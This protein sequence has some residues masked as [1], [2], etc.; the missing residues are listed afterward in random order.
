MRFGS[1]TCACLM[2]GLVFANVASA[3]RLTVTTSRAE[4]LNAQ[5]GDPDCSALSK[6]ADTELPLHIVRLRAVP[7]VGVTGLI[8]Y[9]WSLPTP[10]VGVLVADEDIPS[11]EQAPVIH[12]LCA[13]IGN[14]CILTEEQLKVYS[15]PTILW[16]APKCS[17]ALPAD[18]TKPYR[19]G[20]V[21]VGVRATSGKRKV[22]KGVVSVGY[23]RTASVK[24][25][26]NGNPGQG[27]AV[28]VG[29]E[30]LFSAIIDPSGVQLPLI[31]GFAF[32]NGDGDSGTVGSIGLQAS[33]VLDYS[34]A[35][36]HV[37][38]TTVELHD[39]SALCDN[40]LANVLSSDNRIS[41]S[42]TTNPNPG[43]F[44]PGDPRTGNVDLHVRVKNVSNPAVAR[45]GVLFKGGGV[46]TCETEIRVGSSKLSKTTTIDFQHCS[47]TVDQG[48]DSDADCNKQ[49]CP[50]CE[51]NEVCLAS[52]HCAFSGVEGIRVQ[53]CV[54]D[55]DCGPG[56]QCV[57]VL[58][59]QSLS[60]A[61]G[62][63][64]ELLT[65]RIPI[66][67]TL[68]STAKVKEKWTAHAQNAPDATDSVGYTILSNPSVR[69]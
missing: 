3:R 60:L 36:K 8:R 40:V 61:I 49:A 4:T 1:T 68:P 33:I 43:T 10:A 30:T 11:G 7:P 47:V 16:V 14:E 22:G 52:S 67:N 57:L 66:A 25:A 32:D 63:T 12:A 37:G 31:D 65:A 64:T 39:G 46:L 56:G 5:D 35:G 23:G 2:A 48:C 15:L 21:K 41:L 38:T 6:K 54:R 18:A 24:M 19:G 17:E 9:Q 55:S 29:L 53:P 13:E 59:V 58:P 69:P 34:S 28:D 20:L 42:V 26:L 45:G 27:K 44:R 51:D 62:D 50:A